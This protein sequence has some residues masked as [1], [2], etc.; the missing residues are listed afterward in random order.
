MKRHVA[1]KARY[2]QIERGSFVARKLSF[3]HTISMLLSYDII[4]IV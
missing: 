1:E 4:H 3:W 2:L